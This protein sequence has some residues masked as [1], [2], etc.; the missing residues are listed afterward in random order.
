MAIP[1][2]LTTGFRV[3]QKFVM[4]YIIRYGLTT[5]QARRVFKAGLATTICF[6]FVLINPIYRKLGTSSYLCIMLSAAWHPGRRMGAMVQ[7]FVLSQIGLG[8]GLPYTI[9][10]H[11]TATKVYENTGSL[12]RAL[13]LLVIFEVIMLTMVSYLRVVAP[14]LFQMGFIFFLVVHFSY[15]ENFPIGLGFLAYQFSVPLLASMAVCLLVNVFVFPEF[16]STYIGNT[17]TSAIH[18]A[19]LSLNKATIFFS[20]ADKKSPSVLASDFASVISQRKKV[21]D[22]FSQ[23]QAVMLECTFE[24][25]FAFMAPQELKPMVKLLQELSITES[26]LTVACE[27]EF[28]VF[29]SMNS[30]NNVNPMK[31]GANAPN[32]SAL[33]SN[34]NKSD[35]HQSLVEK[36][37]PTKEVSFA[38]KEVL[39]TFLETVRAPV[40]NLLQVM[41]ESLTDTILTVAQAYDVPKKHVPIINLPDD[42]DLVDPIH[43]KPIDSMFT[44]SRKARVITIEDLDEQLK[45]LVQA[46]NLFDIIVKDALSKISGSDIDT[47]YIMPRDEF[48]LLSSF[49]LNYRES[50]MLISKVLEN[51]R[52][53]LQ[54]R[55]RRQSRGW[56]GRKLWFSIF[57]SKK[58]WSKFL[59][60]GYNEPDEAHCA[61]VVEKKSIIN[62]ED[63]DEIRTPSNKSRYT[64]PGEAKIAPRMSGVLF[65]VRT[66][67][68][69]ALDAMG[70]HKMD[71]KATFQNVFLL[72]LVS[73]PMFS[74]S[75]RSWY[76]DLRGVWVGFI[77]M[78][79][80]EAS[81]GATIYTLIARAILLVV[82]SSWG[83]ALVS[84]ISFLLF[85]LAC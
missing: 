23:C 40:L 46:I 59:K 30:S 73:F 77:A 19:H 8:L 71:I 74:A 35:K 16:G 6:I 32:S 25:S 12:Q 37:K 83:Y 75:M 7:A 18:E 52:T 79:S 9:F 67:L 57:N 28:A 64:T 54:T 21:R 69:D 78:L 10:S 1:Q 2:K 41:S 60:S 27:L 3:V 22:I 31:S 36:L 55:L 53:L 82:G 50:A 45:A 15:V 66:A 70:K 81:V 68:A 24:M 72:M 80:F 17:I 48:F 56:M 34:L 14:R 13:G 43:D 51:S 42:F 26:A 85:N 47:T 11:F 49:L 20:T 44:E 61:S 5:I 58:I 33:T 39:L 63:D 29:S 38:D 65:K 4:K 62:Y 84:N 76:V